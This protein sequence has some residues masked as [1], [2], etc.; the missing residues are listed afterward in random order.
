[1]KYQ[2]LPPCATSALARPWPSAQVSAGGSVK[3]SARHP[4]G[5]NDFSSYLLQAQASGAD[6]IGVCSRR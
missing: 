4:I 6:V 5:S 1:M 2:L 3:G